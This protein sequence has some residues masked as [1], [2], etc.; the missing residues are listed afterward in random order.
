M[1]NPIIMI[2]SYHYLRCVCVCI[3]TVCTLS[4]K[5][6]PH[7]SFRECSPA[8]TVLFTK[9]LAVAVDVSIIWIEYA[10][11]TLSILQYKPTNAHIHLQC[12]Q[13]MPSQDISMR[14]Q[15]PHHTP[16]RWTVCTLRVPW[17]NT[18]P[19]FWTDWVNPTLKAVVVFFHATFLVRLWC[20]LLPVLMFTAELKNSPM[21][22]T[23][24]RQSRHS[25]HRPYGGAPDA[26]K[27]CQ[28]EWIER[29]AVFTHCLQSS[30][31]NLFHAN[32]PS[33]KVHKK[34]G[35]Q[36]KTKHLLLVSASE[37]RI[38]IQLPSMRGLLNVE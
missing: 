32:W 38:A 11:M 12:W 20:K 30:R 8:C 17:K 15:D 21:R 31:C 23:R 28:N 13:E 34:V 37:R 3:C 10:R 25:P 18:H 1:M 7:Y 5:R 6:S 14:N 27:W 26:G 22:T 4:S 2:P 9:Y 16:A 19:P 24:T 33:T 36:S 29:N 35:P